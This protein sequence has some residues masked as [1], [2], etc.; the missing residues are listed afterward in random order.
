MV[1]AP[2]YS[3]V[4]VT[5]YLLRKSKEIIINLNLYKNLTYSFSPEMIHVTQVSN[6]LPLLKKFTCGRHVHFTG[7]V[8]VSYW[9]IFGVVPKVQNNPDLYNE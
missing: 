2:V 5:K 9:P 4:I 1:H 7:S 6:F 3:C 8:G